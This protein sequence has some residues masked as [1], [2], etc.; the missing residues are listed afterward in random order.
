MR[1]RCAA[2]NPS[3][4]DRRGVSPRERD[5]RGCR[6]PA[7]NRRRSAEAGQG[8]AYYAKPKFA[9]VA[10]ARVEKGD[11]TALPFAMGVRRVR[12]GRAG[13]RRKLKNLKMHIPSAVVE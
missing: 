10:H 4:P 9:A 8:A 13:R 1:A 12:P 2:K 6:P 7:R 11:L 5:R 3:S